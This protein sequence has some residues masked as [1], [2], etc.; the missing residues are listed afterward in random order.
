MKQS[1]T[2]IV[3]IVPAFLQGRFYFVFFPTGMKLY[4]EE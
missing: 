2:T 3:T 1:G 4:Q